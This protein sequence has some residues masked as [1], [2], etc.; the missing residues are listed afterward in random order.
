MARNMSIDERSKK[1][2]YILFAGSYPSIYNWS[3][4]LEPE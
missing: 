4:L 3:T 2:R 1:E